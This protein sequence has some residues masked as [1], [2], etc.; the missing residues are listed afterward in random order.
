MNYINSLIKGSDY[1]AT[2]VIG[3]A[4][5]V[6]TSTAI[7][8]I[9]KEQIFE[10]IQNTDDHDAIGYIQKVTLVAVGANYGAALVNGTIIR[11][12]KRCVGCCGT[13]KQVTKISS[14]IL[15]F[16]TDVVGG[17]LGVMGVAVGI[18]YFADTLVNEVKEDQFGDTQ[19]A[20][21][22]LLFF[23]TVAGTT[24]AG[25]A[26]GLGLREFKRLCAKKTELPI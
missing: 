24:F 26:I 16:S 11:F 1:F 18:N 14:E 20:K 10:R 17:C 23:G 19:E 9:V 8:A 15:H 12:V 21:I 4:S 5:T 13:A 25:L 3:A 2:K 7:F 6:V 22:L